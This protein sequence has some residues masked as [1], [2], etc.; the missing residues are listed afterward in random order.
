M[1]DRL[2]SMS[3]WAICVYHQS[4]CG[5]KWRY[6]KPRTLRQSSLT[7]GS[8]NVLWKE[9]IAMPNTVGST[10]KVHCL[11]TGETSLIAR[12]GMPKAPG[13]IQA[14][15]CYIASYQLAISALATAEMTCILWCAALRKK[16]Q[17]WVLILCSWE[18]FFPTTTT[19]PCFFSPKHGL[20]E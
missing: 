15:T 2:V 8:A 20:A 14:I 18:G 13:V 6:S 4:I 17:H 10:S 11:K 12:S 5:L 9:F 7:M 16:K 1:Q 3:I 19:I